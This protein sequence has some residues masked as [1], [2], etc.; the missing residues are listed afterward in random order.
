MIC[1]RVLC[2][3]CVDVGMFASYVLCW[4][5]QARINGMAEC[6]HVRGVLSGM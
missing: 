2:K 3:V 1:A 6:T 4:C 5:A